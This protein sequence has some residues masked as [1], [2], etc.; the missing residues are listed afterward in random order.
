LAALFLLPVIFLLFLYPSTNNYNALD[1]VKG[2]VK[3]ISDFKAKDGFVYKLENQ[4]TVLGFLG[5]KPNEN[6]IT[7]LNLKEVIYDKFQGFKKF[8]V[9][10]VV[11]YGAEKHVALLKKELYQYDLLK[12]WHFV[13]GEASQIK[14]LFNSLRS[15]VTLDETLATSNVFIIDKERNQ[16][17]RLDNREEKEK[18]KN[19]P[20]YGMFSYDCIEVAILKNKMAKEDM[21]VLFTEYRQKRKGD[22]NSTKRRAEDLKSNEQS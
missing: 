19:I 18:E 21:R 20:V 12:Y 8:Q 4:I 6:A 2:D 11:P 7:A 17:G 22:F 1:I 9:V 16:R 5:E 13:Y 15:E 3:E 14:D 10:I